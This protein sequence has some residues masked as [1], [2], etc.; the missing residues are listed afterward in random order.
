MVIQGV[1]I[2]YHQLLHASIPEQPT[3]VFLHDALGCTAMWRDFPER[4]CAA[5]QCDGLVYDRQGHGQSAPL[6][7]LQAPD[8]F[9]H[10][11]QT[12]LPRLLDALAIDH[13]IL[14]GH[15]DGGTIALLHA[16][17]ISSCRA[18]IS[19]AG[20][21]MVEKITKI[22]IRRQVASLAR[23]ATLRKLQRFHG[24]KTQRLIDSWS[25]LWLAPSFADWDIREQ[26]GSVRCPCLILQGETDA[27]ATAEHGPA[28]AHAIGPLARYQS[29]PACGHFPHQEC[30]ED[31]LQAIIAFIQGL[32]LG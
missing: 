32:E 7:D 15:S 14:V 24:E 20:H 9:V 23:A 28:I 1:R 21:V 26:L 31:I 16:A 13:Y 11:A 12:I 6:P 4:L 30:P 27:Y 10:E 8:F 29:L 18:I 22:G 3:L 2:A 5:L 25:G 19:I 17:Q